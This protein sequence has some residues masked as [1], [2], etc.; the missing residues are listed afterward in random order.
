MTVLV[1]PEQVRITPDAPGVG[2][3]AGATTGA[4]AR[5]EYYGHDSVVLVRL[6]SSDVTLPRALPGRGA[7]GRG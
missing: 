2:A 3:R 1:R 7:A 4:V 5:T 6:D